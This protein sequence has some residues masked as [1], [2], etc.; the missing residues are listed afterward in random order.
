MIKDLKS[1][2]SS[3]LLSLT[4]LMEVEV[5][6]LFLQLIFCVLLGISFESD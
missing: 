4:V 6:N 3:T 1:F 5:L 2:D